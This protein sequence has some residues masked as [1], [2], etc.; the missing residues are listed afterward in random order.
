MPIIHVSGIISAVINLHKHVFN[1]Q[2]SEKA[3]I[4]QQSGNETFCLSHSRSRTIS[5]FFVRP[6]RGQVLPL[7]LRR[8]V[9]ALALRACGVFAN[10]ITGALTSHSPAAIALLCRCRAQVLRR[11]RGT[12]TESN[13]IS[14]RKM[15][16]F[17]CRI[18]LRSRLPIPVSSSMPSQS[19]Y[20][21]LT[22]PLF[23]NREE[24]KNVPRFSLRNARFLPVFSLLFFRHR[25]LSHSPRISA[26]RDLCEFRG[27]SARSV[28]LLAAHFFRNNK[29]NKEPGEGERDRLRGR[30]C[31]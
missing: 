31:K 6:P 13:L 12:D 19:I 23:R 1:K 3:A 29:L 11:E 17:L 16:L 15:P 5:L 18:R 22:P 7:L 25:R 26:S 27:L 4:I 10:V 2:A 9:S 14:R 20:H 28:C 24:G 30:K 21:R 8:T